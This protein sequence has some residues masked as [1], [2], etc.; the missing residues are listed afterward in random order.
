MI[1]FADKS[2]EDEWD[3]LLPELQ[4]LMDDFGHWSA[5]QRLPVPVITC[6]KRGQDENRSIYGTDRFSW[7]YCIDGVV[8]AVDIRTRHYTPEQRAKVFAWFNEKCPDSK[9]FELIIKPHGTGP[10]AHI[11]IRDQERNKK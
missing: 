7:H 1:T 9:K 3:L 8:R 6:I 11:A 2:T 4:V 5:A 10:H